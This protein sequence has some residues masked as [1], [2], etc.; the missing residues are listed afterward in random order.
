MS[1]ELAEL[2]L[3][4]GELPPGWLGSKVADQSTLGASAAVMFA[5]CSVVPFPG[6]TSQPSEGRPFQ[7]PRTH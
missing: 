2:A 4:T 1:E 5:P 6:H 7:Q 3:S